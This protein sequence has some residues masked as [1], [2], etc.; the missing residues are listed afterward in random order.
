MKKTLA[1]WTTMALLA[2]G[3]AVAQG[4]AFDGAGRGAGAPGGPGNHLDFLALR[5]NLTDAQKAQ[6]QAIFTAA[7]TQ[8]ATVRTNLTTAR[9]A[10][11]NAIKTAATPA[12]IDTLAANYGV[13]VGQLTAIETKAQAA[14]YAILTTEQKALYD[15]LGGPGHG[16]GPRGAGGPPA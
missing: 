6:A 14:F 5:L 12:Q 9:T 13:L 11:T 10:L 8:S 3:L 15:A 7:E 16:P 1:A 4:P 2:T